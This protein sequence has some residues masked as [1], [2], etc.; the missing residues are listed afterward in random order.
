MSQV[1]AIPD[2]LL[3]TNIENAR[4]SFFIAIAFYS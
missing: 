2:V 4:T 1:C 3:P